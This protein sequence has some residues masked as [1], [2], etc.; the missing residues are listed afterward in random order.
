MPMQRRKIDSKSPPKRIRKVSN[1][2]KDLEKLA[3]AE[4]EKK[5]EKRKTLDTTLESF[6]PL[7]KMP[8]SAQQKEAN[9]TEL[10]FEQLQGELR[11]NIKADT[12]RV[13]DHAVQSANSEL[14]DEITAVDDDV[15][16][17]VT[18]MGK[19]ETRLSSRM[20]N[21][22]HRLEDNED[23]LLHVMK[24]LQEQAIATKEVRGEL[25]D[26][27]DEMVS[28]NYTAINRGKAVM[29]HAEVHEAYLLEEIKESKRTVTV[30][31]TKKNIPE[32][33]GN[34]TTSN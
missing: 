20:D 28:G 19:M 26:L 16:D 23:R 1:R 18:T 5:A 22:D 32:P 15:K 3:E 12:Q 10:M 25:Q 7:S 34:G 27:R 8:N 13:V 2:V 11:N 31:N 4:R 33:K 24:S 6:S 9:A 17:V 21:F 14:M 29:T 30:I